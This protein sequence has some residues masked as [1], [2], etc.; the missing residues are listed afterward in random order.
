MTTTT[1]ITPRPNRPVGGKGQRHERS[2]TRN[3]SGWVHWGPPGPRPP[4]WGR[5]GAGRRQEARGRVVP[6]LRRR[7][8]PRARSEPARELLGRDRGRGPGLEPRRRD[9]AHGLH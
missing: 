8:E 7:G 3:G 5:D 2:D 6:A 4:R 9:G 1:A